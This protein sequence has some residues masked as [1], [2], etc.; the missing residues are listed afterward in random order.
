M[1]KVEPDWTQATIGVSALKDHINIRADHEVLEWFKAKGRGYQ[2]PMKQRAPSNIQAR[3]QRG[4]QRHPDWP[5]RELNIFDILADD[6]AISLVQNSSAIPAQVQ[7]SAVEHV[8]L[9][10]RS[11]R[12]PSQHGRIILSNK[13]D[14]SS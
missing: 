4:D 11:S 8:I 9:N 12:T 13:P 5:P 14:R 3:Q 1:F 6:P 7:T 10:L 2:T